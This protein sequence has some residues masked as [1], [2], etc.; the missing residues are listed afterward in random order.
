VERSTSGCQAAMDRQ[1]AP[2]G[3]DE[4]FQGCAQAKEGSCHGHTIP[5][6]AIAGKGGGWAFGMQFI[7]F[8]ALALVRLL[9]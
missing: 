8:S 6:P 1:G 7:L 3:E 9:G 2:T 4:P 5:R